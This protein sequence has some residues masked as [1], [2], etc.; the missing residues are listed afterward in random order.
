M[1]CTEMARNLGTSGGRIHYHMQQLG[2]V[3]ETKKER[4][5]NDNGNVMPS[6]LELAGMFDED[7]AGKGKTWLI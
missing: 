6:K 5:S 3:G 1:S 7:A 4:Q 2:I